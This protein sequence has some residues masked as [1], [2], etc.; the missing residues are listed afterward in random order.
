MHGTPRP[1]FEPGN[2]YGKWISNPPQYQVVPSWQL[3][4]LKQ[5]LPF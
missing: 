3:L 1:G 5:D 2:P 4:P